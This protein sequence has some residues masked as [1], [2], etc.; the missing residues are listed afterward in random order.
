MANDIVK[1]TI[2][3]HVCLRFRANH[4][5]EPL[6]QRDVPEL[7]WQRAAID[8][9][10]FKCHDYLVVLDCYSK[11]PEIALLENKTAAC[12][13]NHLKSIFTRHGIAE[14]YFIVE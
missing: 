4:Q 2:Q 9:M 10:T 1:I 13:I 11:Y 6:N 5:T 12:V 8:N 14:Q 3:S 7:P